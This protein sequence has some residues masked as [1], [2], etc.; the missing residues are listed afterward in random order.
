MQ[1]SVSPECQHNRLIR[2][3]LR[4]DG[5]DVVTGKPERHDELNGKKQD[6]NEPIVYRL[7]EE[8]CAL[9]DR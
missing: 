5:A 7:M 2:D 8:D 4:G 6:I 1:K 3:T 9:R